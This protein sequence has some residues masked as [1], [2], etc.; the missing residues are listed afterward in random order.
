MAKYT[1]EDTTL[2]NIA[3]A[4]REKTKKTNSIPVS[5]FNSEIA[6]I[7]SGDVSDYFTEKATT[8]DVKKWIKKIPPTDLS[9]LSNGSFY[10]MFYQMNNLKEVELINSE[11]IGGSAN[12]MFANTTSLKSYKIN[13]KLKNCDTHNALFTYSGIEKITDI[14]TSNSTNLGTFASYCSNLTTIDELDGSKSTAF[15][16]FCY[17]S[18]KLT[19]FGGI[20]DMGKA[21]LTTQNANYSLYGLSLSSNNNLTHES[22]MNVINNLYDIASIGVQPQKLTLGSTNLA[23][24]TEEE[25]AIA[26]N[27]GWNVL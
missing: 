27:K 21:Y 14:D 6:S 7:Q 12:Y 4:I 10:Q 15:N 3:N 9:S 22:L 13:G 1:I 18:G 2:T 11:H 20:K 17:G 25:I 23:K 5:S 19:N 8:T 26:Q 24:L 16:N